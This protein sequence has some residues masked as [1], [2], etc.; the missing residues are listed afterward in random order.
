MGVQQSKLKAL[1]HNSPFTTAP[2]FTRPM[3]LYTLIARSSDGCILVEATTP[4]ITGNHLQIT[5]QLL[6]KLTA[7][8]HIIP[9]GN[10][11]SFTNSTRSGYNTS[12]SINQWGAEGG[13]VDA[14]MKSSWNNFQTEEV[15]D[16]ESHTSNSIN[17]DIPHYFH[18]QRG[19]SVLFIA[20]SDDAASQNHRINFSFLLDVQKEFVKKYTPNKILK[21][22]AYG[23]EKAFNKPLSNMM[24]HCNTNR[25]PI[26]KITKHSML[27]AE[28]E[29]IKKVLGINIDL[30]MTREKHMRDLMHQS[31]DLLVDAK[32][33]SKRGRKLKRAMKKREW[34]YKLI[35]VMFGLLTLYLMMAKLCGFGLKCVAAGNGG[36]EYYGNGNGGNGDDNE[37]G[38]NDDGMND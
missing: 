5:N 15:Y 29:S 30:L 24:H 34:V 28:V 3:L 6:Q 21:A 31:N 23:M 1:T 9:V 20:L 7:N 38:G 11:K 8:P 18:V 16:S 37:G 33:F 19:E 26:G 2:A 13:G 25:N 36:D 17:T 4:G 27:N 32:V 10:R 14:K 35:L 12:S 22:N